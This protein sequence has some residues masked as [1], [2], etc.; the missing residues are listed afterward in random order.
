MLPMTFRWLVLV[1]LAAVGM[2]SAF[3]ETHSFV[4]GSLTQI[5]KAHLG[6]PFLLMVW[7]LDCSSCLRELDLLAAQAK[8][9]PEMALIMVSTD[10]LSRQSGVEQML[11]KHGLDRLESWIF[12]EDDAQRLRYEIDRTWHGEM[13]RSYFYNRQHQRTSLSGILTAQH[14][15]A[16]L[17]VVNG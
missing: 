13:P 14:I 3:A 1:V 6:R 12:A 4:S 9:H 15:D 2:G 16:W 10:E 17:A 8:R 11:A 7:S 5:E